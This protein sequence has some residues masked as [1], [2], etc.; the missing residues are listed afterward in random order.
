MQRW[1]KRFLASFHSWSYRNPH[2]RTCKRCG[3]IQN[4]FGMRMSDTGWWEDMNDGRPAP[5][6]QRAA[7]PLQGE[8]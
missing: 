7:R 8:K 5:C 6:N 2:D 4:R 1:I 3:L